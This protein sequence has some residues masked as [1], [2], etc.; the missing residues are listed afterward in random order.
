[1]KKLHAVVAMFALSLFAVV[2]VATT[3]SAAGFFVGSDDGNA[4]LAEGRTIDGS[5]YMAGSEVIVDGT[6][7]GDLY[8]AGET[9]TV[10]GTV[11]GDVICAGATVTINGVVNGDVRVAGAD[12]TLGGEVKGN[13]LA[14]ASTL[15]TTDTFM[16]TGDFTAGSE[17]MDLN[18]SIGRDA[19]VGASTLTLRGTITRDL[20]AD[21]EELTTQDGAKVAGNVWYKA[22]KPTAA[23]GAFEDKVHF[24]Q[25]EAY[26]ESS[27]DI[28]TVLLGI[29]MLIVFAV[30]SVLAVPR[31]IHTAA[32]LAPRQALFAFLIGLTAVIITP[33][34]AII[35]MVTVVGIWVGVALLLVWLLAMIASSVFFSYYI[36]TLALQ[37]R[38]TNALLVALTGSAI[39]SIALLVPF[40]NALVFVVMLFVGVG[41]QVMHLRHQFSKDPYTIAA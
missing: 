1:M 33:I 7:K 14:G 17:T 18:G 6:V 19:L 38:A 13:V 36:G 34:V 27:M 3:A 9:V 26:D 8:C 24:E 29:L 21:V 35:F 22:P 39:L 16:L 15:I 20:S 10:E 31:F 12:V 30:V 25:G 5:A 41:M 28:T 40:I 37:K 23:T 2:G 11:E 4:V 32:T